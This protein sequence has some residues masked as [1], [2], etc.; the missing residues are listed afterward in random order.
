MRQEYFPKNVTRRL[1]WFPYTIGTI[2]HGDRITTMTKIFK[3]VPSSID[4]GLS[5][6]VL[7]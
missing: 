6:M 4:V 1:R 7:M 3:P 5:L 2:E